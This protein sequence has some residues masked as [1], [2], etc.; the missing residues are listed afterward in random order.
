MFA[1]GKGAH[2][3]FFVGID[4][5]TSG[6]RAVIMDGDG[7]ILAAGSGEHTV[8]TP[9]PGYSEQDPPQWWQATIAAVRAAMAKSG[10]AAGEVAAI[11]FSGQMHGLVCL[12]AAGGVLRPAI[13]W[14]DQ[15]TGEQCE[16]ITEQ[17]GG[18]QKLIELCG[19][20]A[21]VSFTLTKLLWVKKYE[22]EIYRRLAH[23]LLPKDYVRY[24]MTGLFAGDIS[25]MSG[26]MMLDQRKRNWSDEMLR[27][28][29]IDRA[30]LPPVYESHEVVGPL[31]AEAAGALGLTT[32]TLVVAGGGD[33]PVGAVGAGV[34]DAGLVSAT[35]GTSGVVFVHAHEYITDPAGRVQT[36]CS[37]VAGQ[38][39]LFG[40][41]LAAGGSL[42]WFRN[43]LGQEE[44]RDAAADGSDPYERLT[45]L[46]EKAPAGGEGL[47][48]LP[49]LTGERTPY[50]DPNARACW[51]GITPRTTRA[52][53][54][55]SVME[56]A[57]FA[58]NDVL[59]ILRQRGLKPAQVRLAGGGA[60]S[61]F[62]RQLQADIYAAPC[63]TINATE[64]PAFGAAILAAVGAGAFP[65]V[66]DAC[67]QLIRVAATIKPDRDRAKFYRRRHQ[68]Y[69]RLYPALRAQFKRIAA[70]D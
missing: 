69:R 67:R 61:A 11:G 15:R 55:R 57:T 42:Q 14:N 34:V 63:A 46:A 24:R 58:M 27:L 49:Y 13:I 22:P 2:M 12:D 33:Q 38:Y 45:A 44:V 25:D 30:I 43:V 17:A 50:A 6:S 41:V 68:Q 35:M 26:T 48:W 31:T 59:A 21:M 39:C 29:D 66:P 40:C 19:N 3:A 28:F 23:L 5:G 54:V 64:G 8:Q 32:R 56:G 52:E 62:W 51:I 37:S 1:Q 18:P 60:R 4:V 10:V 70:L 36:F 9:R 20:V 16:F 7:R 53:L 65:S 47:F